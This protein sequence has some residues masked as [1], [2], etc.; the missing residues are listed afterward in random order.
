MESSSVV[1]VRDARRFPL[2]LLHIMRS[3]EHLKRFHF[4]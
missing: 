2:G 1:V 4:L 3:L